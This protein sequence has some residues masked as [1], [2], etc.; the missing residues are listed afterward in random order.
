MLAKE[1]RVLSWLKAA[2]NR[3]LQTTD[4]AT[5]ELTAHPELDWETIGRLLSVKVNLLLGKQ[6]VHC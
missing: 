2:Y 3:L 5:N 6:P 4:L 1:Y